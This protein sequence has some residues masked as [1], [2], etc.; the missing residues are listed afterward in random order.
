M[1]VGRRKRARGER[2]R[3]GQQNPGPGAASRVCRKGYTARSLVAWPERESHGQGIPG[4]SWGCLTSPQV[5][6]L[7][8]LSFWLW[9]GPVP[10]G[11]CRG[12]NSFPHLFWLLEAPACLGLWPLPHR[13]SCLLSHFLVWLSLHLPV[14]WPVPCTREQLRRVGAQPPHRRGRP[15]SPGSGTLICTEEAQVGPAIVH[16]VQCFWK[17]LP[18]VR[19][20]CILF[21]KRGPR[22]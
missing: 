2:L 10:A 6:G 7:V 20:F 11:G 15:M 13:N 12:E 17:K 1:G 18:K 14:H 8:L 22:I 21:Y 4:P 5:S 9:A 16:M 19:Y 3:T